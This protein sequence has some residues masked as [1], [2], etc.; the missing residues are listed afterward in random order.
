ML[1]R[2]APKQDSG[3]GRTCIMIRVPEAKAGEASLLR[4]SAMISI[5]KVSI[6]PDN[7]PM[8]TGADLQNLQV[9]KPE[10]VE[11]IHTSDTDKMG[12]ALRGSLVPNIIIE[13]IKESIII[14]IRDMATDMIENFK[15]SEME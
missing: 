13:A 1:P 14:P 5:N 4:K 6:V 3:M 9:I 15:K 8:E 11:T 12:K 10:A 2:N 7:K